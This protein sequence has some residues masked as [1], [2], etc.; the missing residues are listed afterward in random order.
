MC[1]VVTPVG[2]VAGVF[3]QLL[4]LL[5]VAVQ[6][7]QIEGVEECALVSALV[8]D[9]IERGNAVIIAGDSLAID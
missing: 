8:T 5:I 9:E 2:R 4:Y 7:D 6:F 1:E 3:Q